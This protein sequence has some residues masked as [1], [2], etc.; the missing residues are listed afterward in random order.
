M[1]AI[2]RPAGARQGKGGSSDGGLLR[3]NG[4]Q[5]DGGLLL[6][7]SG[8]GFLP[9]QK[10]QPEESMANARQGKGGSSDGGLLR[11]SGAQ[12]DGGLLLSK[13]A[14]G[15]LRGSRKAEQRRLLSSAQCKATFFVYIAYIDHAPIRLHPNQPLPPQHDLHRKNIRPPPPPNRTQRRKII[16]HRQTPPLEISLLHMV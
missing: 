4:K 7:K 10:N 8:S 14:S 3:G 12:S 9:G 15:L 5:S 16:P 13:S 11:G 6:S 2:A 1:S